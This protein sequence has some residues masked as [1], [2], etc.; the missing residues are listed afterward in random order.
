MDIDA[1]RSLFPV[2]ENFTYLNNAAESPMNL[3]V[4]KALDDYVDQALTRPQEKQSPR[5]GVR[6]R[7]AALFGGAA[8]DYA[9]VTS[10][11]VGIGLVARGFPW[12]PGDN[13]VL[14]A[15][16]HWNN[17]FP[18]L[19]LRP[20]GVEVRLVEPEADERVPVA[21]MAAAIDD[22]TRIVATAAVRFT[23]GFRADLPRLS[24]LAHAKGALFL[25]D[26][27]QAAGVC[28]L[29]VAA[30]GID[31]MA[32]AGFKWLLGQPGCG[33]LYLNAKARGLVEPLLPGM[34]AAVNDFRRLEYYDDARRYETGT[35]A[36]P[37]FH[38]WTAGLD[39]LAAVGIPNIHRRVMELTSYLA[40]RLA[41]SALQVVTPM[42]FE[43]ERSAI[44]TCTSGNAGADK[45]LVQ[46][47]ADRNVIVALRDGR[48]R[49]S[50]NFFNTEADIDQLV[51]E[52]RG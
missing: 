40:A 6:R 38:A 13:V 29:D 51:E 10:T 49:I 23:S 16:E 26:A 11:G 39:L 2:C 4:K 36:Y 15:D 50:P 25:V 17:T 12:R 37:L 48:V 19:A 44:V 33:F 24:A 31:I 52:L 7:C 20:L 42:D 8:E 47:L 22:R 1:A 3:L 14:P 41:G 34:F 32:A 46:Q 27:I 28:P 43:A 30:D 21:K 45:A 9:L 5:D 18:W 35:F